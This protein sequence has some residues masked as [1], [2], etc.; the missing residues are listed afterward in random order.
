MNVGG[1]NH[2]PTA[3]DSTI[4]INKP[5][6]KDILLAGCELEEPT[7]NLINISSFLSL[8]FFFP[9]LSVFLSPS[10]VHVYDKYLQE[11]S[12]SSSLHYYLNKYEIPL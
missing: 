3:C 5:C 1:I 8:F 10:H 12:F 7:Y 2:C 6:N 9:L 11:A 4:Q